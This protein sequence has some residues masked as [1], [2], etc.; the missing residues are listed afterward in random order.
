[1]QKDRSGKYLEAYPDVFADIVN[2]LLFEELVIKPEDLR[3]GPTE[4]IYKAEQGEGLYE[5]RRDVA[6]YVVKNG[7]E[8]ALIGVE[9][10]TNVDKDMVFRIMGYDYASYRSQIGMGKSRYPVVSIVLYFGEKP[11]KKPVSM[12]EVFTNTFDSQCEWPDYKI[13]LID[14]GRMPKE[15]RQKFTSDFRVVADFFADRKKQEYIPDKRKLEHPEAVLHLLTV[16]TGDKRYQEI[17]AEISECCKKGES[18]SMCEFAERMEQK[19]IRKGRKEGI[20]M[21]VKNMLQRGMSDKDICA[22]A[23]CSQKL[24]DKL[25]KANN[26]SC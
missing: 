11:W 8:Y 26:I 19:G 25:R 7:T 4:S 10:Q 1:M 2:V 23:E 13:R 22:I 9:N 21:I 20:E 5:Q 14:V 24:V 12:Q 6:K 17:E 3:N 15:T 16:F 18:F